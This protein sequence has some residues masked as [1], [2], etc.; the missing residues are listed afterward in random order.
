MRRQLEL[1]GPFDAAESRTIVEEDAV[2]KDREARLYLKEIL[3][4]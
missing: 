2:F 1:K 3:C 4:L